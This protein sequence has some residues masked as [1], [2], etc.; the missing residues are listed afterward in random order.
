MMMTAGF[1]SG[2][3]MTAQIEEQLKASPPGRNRDR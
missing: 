1:E 3:D 2:S